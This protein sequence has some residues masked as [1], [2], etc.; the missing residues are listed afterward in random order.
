MLES[1]SRN[2]D[3][4]ET[5]AQCEGKLR[6]IVW[7]RGHCGFFWNFGLIY[8]GNTPFSYVSTVS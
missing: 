3:A 1:E 8:H 2:G 7:D 6:N 4:E 5:A